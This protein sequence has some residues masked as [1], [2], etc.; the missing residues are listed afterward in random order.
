MKL[1]ESLPGSVGEN[2]SAFRLMLRSCYKLQRV[3]FSASRAHLYVYVNNLNRTGALQRWVVEKWVICRT[4]PTRRTLPE[5][6]VCSGRLR[7]HYLT[8]YT[9]L[10]LERALV[11][12]KK[13]APSLTASTNEKRDW[14]V[15]NSRGVSTR[16]LLQLVYL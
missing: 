14:C 7:S 13:F 15:F 6:L 11:E 2:A 3:K 5:L 4:Y 16:G 8:H 1:L 10:C 12:K 9:F